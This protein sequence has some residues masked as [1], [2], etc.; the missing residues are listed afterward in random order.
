MD[1]R[2]VPPMALA[3]R[4]ESLKGLR[5]GLLDNGKEFSDLVLAGLGDVLEREFGAGEIVFWRKGFP[6]KAAPFIPEMAAACDVAISGV[7]H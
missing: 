5:V 6:S 1:Q 7:G 2:K 3:A 4:P